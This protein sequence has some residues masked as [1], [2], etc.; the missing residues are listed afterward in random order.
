MTDIRI[1]S[2]IKP[3]HI[4][5]RT[6]IEAWFYHGQSEERWPDW[7]RS[8]FQDRPMYRPRLNRWALRDDEGYF[9]RWMDQDKFDDLFE[10][11]HR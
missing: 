9:W 1:T 10:P 2:E 4:H 5:R 11:L 7:V 3:T 8:A 6:P